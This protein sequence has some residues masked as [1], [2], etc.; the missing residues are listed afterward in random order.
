MSLLHRHLF[1]N[2]RRLLN[3]I[4]SPSTTNT[5]A[6]VVLSLD[7]EKAFDRVEW[8]VCLNYWTNLG[9]VRISFPGSVF[10]THPL[11]PVFTQLVSTQHPSHL[12][13]GTRHGCPLLPLLFALAIEPLAIMLKTPTDLQGIRR[14]NMEY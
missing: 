5:K 10:F 11:R 2:I 13:R 3:I 6:E 12:S 1:S 7:A 8:V 14:G 9:L 4:S